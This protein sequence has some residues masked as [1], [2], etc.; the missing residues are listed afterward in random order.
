[1]LPWVTTRWHKSF[2]ISATKALSINKISEIS[3]F[4]TIQMHLH[5]HHW[6]TVKIPLLLSQWD[7]LEEPTW[8][9]FSLCFCRSNFVLQ[10]K[11][12]LH[13]VAI[14]LV[15]FSGN[16]WNPADVHRP[17]RDAARRQS[18]HREDQVRRS[19][20]VGWSGLLE[21]RQWGRSLNREMK[22]GNIGLALSMVGKKLRSSLGTAVDLG[23]TGKDGVVHPSLTVMTHTHTH[24]PANT[25]QFAMSSSTLVHLVAFARKAA[26]SWNRTSSSSAPLLRVCCT[27]MER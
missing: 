24:I 25:G 23:L 16:Q 2:S 14:S 3:A 9:K 19:Y 22:K 26:R 27:D 13:S 17:D 8:L 21:E 1:M 18:P 12:V 7:V 15:V 10:L 11:T 20:A 4:E 6:E 5:C